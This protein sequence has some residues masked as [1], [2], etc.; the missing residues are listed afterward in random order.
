MTTTTNSFELRTLYPHSYSVI[1]YQNGVLFRTRQTCDQA[2]I[3]YVYRVVGGDC[4][5]S[6]DYRSA[7]RPVGM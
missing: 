7:L 5:I 2:H 6:G 4:L 3:L 1:L